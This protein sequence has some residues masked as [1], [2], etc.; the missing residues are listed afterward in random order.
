MDERLFAELAARLREGAV[1]VASVTGTRGATPR[2]RGSRMLVAPAA[3]HASIGGGAAEARVIEAARAL[4]LGGD[5]R[6]EIAI[7][8]S[9][10]AGA[11]GVCGGSMRIALQRWHGAEDAAR[12]RH[13]AATLA[14]GQRMPAAAAGLEDDAPLEPDPRLLVVGAGH[15]GQALC[16]LAR[17]LA[18]DLWV[19]DERAHALDGADYAGATRRSGDPSRLAEAFATA[20][21]VHAVLLNRDYASD[22]ASLRAIAAQP[23]VFLGMMGS[24]KRIG[25]VLAALEPGVRARIEPRLRAPVGLAIGAQTPHEIAVSILAELIQARARPDRD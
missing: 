3:T 1:V 7:D 6:G 11:A 14:A 23:L 19:F 18:F 15:C 21:E 22:V 4:L 13:I 12:A 24:R 17:P 5:D 20:R 8:L 10:R 25:T 16:E 9:G 2:K